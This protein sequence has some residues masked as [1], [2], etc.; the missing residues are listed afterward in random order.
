MTYPKI[1]SSQEW[2]RTHQEFLKDEKELT[3]RRDA[4]N[5]RR[6]RLPMMAVDKSY[7]FASLQGK[8]SF[9]DLFEGR[10]QLI[11]YHNMLSSDSSDI[12][13]GCSLFGDNLGRFDH[14]HARRTTFAMVSDANVP[15]I[16]EVKARMG[17]T[18]PWYSCEGTRFHDDFIT[19]EN[20]Y[21]GLSVF[22][23]DGPDIFRT[24]FSTGRG[25][26]Y[27]SNTFSL[28]DLTPWGRQ[29]AW[30]DSPE[31]TPQEP[32]HSWLRLH[33]EYALA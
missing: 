19:Q 16:E 22:I 6:R 13:K 1:V 9:H 23:T 33:D 20:A 32:T 5:A 10:P 12:C 30:E 31:G 24:Y 28:L 27:A 14:L 15:Q 29:E 18:I 26:E 7:T 17:W 25:V 4:L 8:H 11:V 21:F 2:R 3:H